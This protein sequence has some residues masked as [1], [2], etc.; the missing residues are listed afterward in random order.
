MGFSENIL[1]PEQREKAAD[2]AKMYLDLPELRQF[3]IY[4]EIKGYHECYTDI[5]AQKRA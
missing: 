2:I 4:F 3:Q 5:M 1:T